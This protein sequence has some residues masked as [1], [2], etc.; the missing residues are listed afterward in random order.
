MV[1]NSCVIPVYKSRY[2]DKK[3]KPLGKATV[4]YFKFN[5]PLKN[6]FDKHSSFIGFTLA[7]MDVKGKLIKSALPVIGR[8]E[9]KDFSSAAH[10]LTYRFCP[11]CG[12]LDSVEQYSQQIGPECVFIISSCKCGY[13][14]EDVID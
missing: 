8:I 3:E 11:Q 5:K 1:G 10:G 4:A 13:K 2:W 6:E 12:S 7:V 14:N 9:K